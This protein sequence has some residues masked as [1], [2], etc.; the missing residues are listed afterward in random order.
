MEGIAQIAPEG[1]IIEQCNSAYARIL[2][3]TPKEAVGRSFFEFVEGEDERE[4]RHQRELRI[5]G[6]GSKYEVSITAADG[7]RKVLS[8]G[9][10][11]LLGADGSYEG[12]V[13]TVFDVTELRER[14]RA[15]RAS[16]EMSGGLSRQRGRNSARGAGRTLAQDQQSRNRRASAKTCTGSLTP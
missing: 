5:S 10:Y 2:C 7:K 4:A 3:L 9:G 1:G 13:Q 8:C 6:T 16:E 11:P 15:L 12:A 14:E